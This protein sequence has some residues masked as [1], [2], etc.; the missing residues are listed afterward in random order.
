MI[1]THIIETCKKGDKQSYALI[2][3]SA[4]P[5]V[6]SIVRRYIEDTEY[7]KDVMQ[8][9]FAKVFLNIKSFDAEKG[10][11]KGWIRK[12][13]VNECLLHLRG[14][15]NG[16]LFV[17]YAA[18]RI[19]EI[20]DDSKLPTDLS[21]A[22]I[23]SILEKMPNGYRLVFMLS[24][25]DEYSHKEIS[26]TLNITPETSRSQLVRSKRWLRNFLNS[27]HKRDMYGLL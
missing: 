15:S 4:A 10:P 16:V 17:E 27:Q 14:K 6:Y 23:E 22:E 20:K 18:E 3:K 11:F 21:R 24:V 13:A 12:V 1:N 8:E 5:Y 7:R 26:K 2:Y 9:T 25:L 19:E